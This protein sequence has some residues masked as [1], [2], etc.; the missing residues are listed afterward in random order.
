MTS[1][2]RAQKT[3]YHLGELRGMGVMTKEEWTAIRNKTYIEI[4]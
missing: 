4:K 2:Q 3:V 1:E